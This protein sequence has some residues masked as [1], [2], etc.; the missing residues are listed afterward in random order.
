MS[1]ELTA[2]EPVP[3]EDKMQGINQVVLMG[4]L[5]AAPELKSTAKGRNLCHM[6]LATNHRRREGDVWHDNVTWHDVTLWESQAETAAKYLEAGDLVAVE[7]HLAPRTWTDAEGNRRRRVDVV[8]KKLHFVRKSTGQMAP[9]NAPEATP[10]TADA[11]VRQSEA[12]SQAA[13]P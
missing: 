1:L 9:L 12:R 2:P 11:P 13:L 10:S 7:G 3:M 6:R 4:R 5:G 8:A